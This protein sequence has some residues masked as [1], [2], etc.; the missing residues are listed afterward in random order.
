MFVL[1]V[2]TKWTLE[3]HINIIFISHQNFNLF[4]T[5]AADIKQVMRSDIKA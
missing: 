4:S 1:E 2:D 5:L 3:F